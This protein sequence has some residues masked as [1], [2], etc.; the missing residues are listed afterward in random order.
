MKKNPPQ[1]SRYKYPFLLSFLASFI[2]FL[3]LSSFST[4]VEGKGLDQISSQNPANQP[5]PTPVPE[6]GVS[7]PTSAFSQS[8]SGRAFLAVSTGFVKA[9][10]SNGTWRSSR[11]I[12]D[13]FFAYGIP[14]LSQDIPIYATYR[15]TPVS[16]SGTE[17]GHEYR[18]IWETHALGAFG[19]H[20]LQPHL[21][22]IAG[23][24]LGYILVHLKP[25]DSLEEDKE[26][27]KNG[28]TFTIL[29]GLEYKLLEEKL[30]VGP[31]LHLGIG[32]TQIYQ[33]AIS[34]GF[35]F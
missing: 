16:V 19:K 4:H 33:L 35:Y 23:A 20:P 10:K 24:E 9:S 25:L 12:S 32:T 26:A 5:P 14:E 17:K 13:I 1:R 28:I 8:L 3:S 31:R 22:A 34:T 7:Q 6:S 11:G 21:D 15:Y 30:A 18:G 2:S 27:E 29:G